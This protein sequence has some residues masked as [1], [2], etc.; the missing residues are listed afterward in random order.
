MELLKKLRSVR[1]NSYKEMFLHLYGFMVL[2]GS[3]ESDNLN[4]DI[5]KF[6]KRLDK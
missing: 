5:E 6:E 1:I 2:S 4:G 3:I